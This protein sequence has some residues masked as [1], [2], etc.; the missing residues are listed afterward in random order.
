LSFA[1]C[2]LLFVL[3]SIGAADII[4]V[5]S[6]ADVITQFHQ[7]LP[8]DADPTEASMENFPNVVLQTLSSLLSSDRNMLHCVLEMTSHRPVRA[9][10][11]SPAQP[12]LNLQAG[13]GPNAT[14]ASALLWADVTVVQ[15]TSDLPTLRKRS[16]EEGKNYII[17][18]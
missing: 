13:V 18:Y 16:R 15:V 1:L 5:L 3:K 11:V 6:L 10:W 17:Q 12:V 14:K 8:M 4:Y 9:G 7:K 2:S